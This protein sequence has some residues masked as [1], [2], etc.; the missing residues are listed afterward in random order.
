[1]ITEAISVVRPAQNQGIV[2]ESLPNQDASEFAIVEGQRHQ[3]SLRYYQ[4]YITYDKY[5]Q[6]PRLWLQASTADGANLTPKDVMQ[7]VSSEYA[8]KTVTIEYFPFRKKM[9]CAS[10]HPCRHA[11]V[12]RRMVANALKP[13][14]DQEGIRVDQYLVLFLK[15]M[16]SVIP[17]IEYDNTMSM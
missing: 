4:L 7:D 14:G 3:E 10:I 6:T 12:M 11:S 16:S 8:N 13:N 2:Q 1:L 17:T 9:L 5:Y 15:F